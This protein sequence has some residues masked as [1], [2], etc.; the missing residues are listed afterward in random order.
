MAQQN[1]TNALVG[2]VFLAV[3]ILIAV[4]YCSFSFSCGEGFEEGMNGAAQAQDATVGLSLH[5][6]GGIVA[7]PSTQKQ[8]KINNFQAGYKILCANY[9]RVCKQLDALVPRRVRIVRGVELRKKVGLSGD[10]Y[11]EERSEIS[12]EYMKLH[13]EWKRLEK[14]IERV[15]ARAARLGYPLIK[16]KRCP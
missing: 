9:H 10:V 14:T 12:N 6:G 15:E 13:D 3:L 1:L 2:F 4:N 16:C 5:R 7:L 11:N 8:K